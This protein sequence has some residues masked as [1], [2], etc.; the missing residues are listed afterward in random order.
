[1]VRLRAYGRYVMQIIDPTAFVNEIVGTRGR[2]SSDD[3][4]D[5]LRDI[6][7]S[8][9]NDMLGE[10]VKTLLD[11]PAQYD[12]LAQ[13]LQTRCADDFAR[14]GLKL[15]NLYL[16]G[17][18]PPE[19]VQQ[20]IDERAGMGAVGNLDQYMKFKAA[21]ALEKAAEN[22]G[23]AGE[24]MGMGMGAGMGFAM[25]GN[26]MRQ[27]GGGTVPEGTASCGACGKPLIPGASFCAGCGTP[28]SAGSAAEAGDGKFCTGCGAKLP[29][30]A[31]FC[32]QCGT[33]QP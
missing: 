32:S 2:Y 8:R 15:E 33:E 28:V 5:F 24:G 11:L 29:G 19:E 3:I 31:R 16:M 13:E 22:P 27:M 12:E 4:Q 30:E 14:Y 25:M 10:K 20:K 7:V 9:L 18:N 1:M 26:M 23:G 21:S 17:I 6:I